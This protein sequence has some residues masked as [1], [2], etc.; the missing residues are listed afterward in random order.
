VLS[1]NSEEFSSEGG[2]DFGYELMFKP[3]KNTFTASPLYS[4]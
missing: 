3:V 2:G 1:D 4:G